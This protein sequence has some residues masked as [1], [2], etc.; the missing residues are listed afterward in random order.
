L[1][2][3]TEPLL[4]LADHRPAPSCLPIFEVAD[5]ESDEGFGAAGSMPDKG[6]L[7]IPNGLCAIFKDTSGNEFAIFQDV[8]PNVFGER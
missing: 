8:R 2:L 7:E 3:G 6:P 1:R 4:L 5:L